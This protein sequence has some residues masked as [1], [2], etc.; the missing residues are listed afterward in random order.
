MRRLW[1]LLF[2]ALFVLSMTVRSQTPSR[3]DASAKSPTKRWPHVGTW[4]AVASDWHKLTGEEVSRSGPE[5]DSSYFIFDGLGHLVQMNTPVSTQHSKSNDE[6]TPA[7]AKE[8]VDGHRQLPLRNASAYFGTY[9]LNVPQKF[10]VNFVV[11]EINPSD[12]RQ[13]RIRLFDFVGNR[14]NLWIL[15]MTRP[16]QISWRIWEKVPDL[17]QL[18]ATHQKLVGFWNVISDERRTASGEVYSSRPVELGYLAYSAVGR[19]G[20]HLLEP[21][22][23]RWVGARPTPD[24]AKDALTSYT[25]YTGLYSIDEAKHLVTHQGVG[26]IGGQHAA[27][28]QYSYDLSGNRL[29][30]S[31]PLMTVN[32]Q[33]LR[34][35]ITTERISGTDPIDQP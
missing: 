22:R 35:V 7:E 33:Q 13:A 18:T 28:A 31:S 21:N 14:V 29:V 9:T 8:I 12:H 26:H 23:Q 5:T 34:E 30:L 16:D 19:M 11:G 6:L 32:G 25:A 4:R 17:P 10:I 15:P 27:D 20:F 3:S 2:S 24:E 1:M